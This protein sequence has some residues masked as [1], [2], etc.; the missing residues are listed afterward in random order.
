MVSLRTVPAPA[1]R[2]P[3]RGCQGGLRAPE[4]EV[5][6]ALDELLRCCDQ[7]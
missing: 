2:G 1:V 3:E 6:A 5:A 7:A 4:P